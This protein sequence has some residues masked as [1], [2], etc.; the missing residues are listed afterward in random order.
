MDWLPVEWDLTRLSMRPLDYESGCR[1]AVKYVLD[2]TFMSQAFAPRF[3]GQAGLKRRCHQL[4]SHL[5]P[6]EI[7]IL[8]RKNLTPLN[9][10][11]PRFAGRACGSEP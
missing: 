11:A 5:S 1:Y 6:F 10:A 2:V 4:Q 7:S 9:D 8:R 3:S